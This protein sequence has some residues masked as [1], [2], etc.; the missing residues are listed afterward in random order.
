MLSMYM[1]VYPN[2][3]LEILT[4]LIRPG[5]LA[6]CPRSA[7]SKAIN[8]WGRGLLDLTQLRLGFAARVPEMDT[9]GTVIV[10]PWTHWSPQVPKNGL[11]DDSQV[12]FVSDT[13]IG[14]TTWCFFLSQPSVIHALGFWTQTHSGYHRVW[15]A[16]ASGRRNTLPINPPVSHVF[17]AEFPIESTSFP[18]FFNGISQPPGR[19]LASWRASGISWGAPWRLRVRPWLFSKLTIDWFG[20]KHDKIHQYS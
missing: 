3:S 11:H 7:L 10:I 19:S 1:H 20:T 15:L 9:L 17:P 8:K 12:Y 5:F 4:N 16:V 2:I 13:L 6:G 18:A 14:D